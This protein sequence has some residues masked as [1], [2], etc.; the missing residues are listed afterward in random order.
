MVSTKNNMTPEHE[1]II[2]HLRKSRDLGKNILAVSN[3]YGSALIEH[4]FV[5]KTVVSPKVEMI[6]EIEFLPIIRLYK[7]DKNKIVDDENLINEDI[8]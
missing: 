1:I 8:E 3:E 7:S 6:T 5:L 2:K 4:K